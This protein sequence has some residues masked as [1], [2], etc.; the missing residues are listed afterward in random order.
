M[1]TELARQVKFTLNKH[2]NADKLSIATIDGMDWQ[3]VTQTE[4]WGDVREGIYIAIDALL[5]VS[6]PSFDFLKDKA[7][8]KLSNGRPAHKL[9]TIRLRGAL[10]HGLLIP[11]PESLPG[12]LPGE[13]GVEIA[14]LGGHWGTWTEALGIERY[15]PPI[16]SN[17]SGDMIR[18]PG[19]FQ[20]YT[21][22]ENAKN[23]P[24][25]FAEGDPVRVTEKIHGTNFRVAL[26]VDGMVT[27][28]VAT[29]TYMVGTHN[30][31]RDPKGTNAYSL[32][33]AKF[34]PEDKVRALV[35]NDNGSWPMTEHYII[36]AELFGSG[37]Q[38]LT[39]GCEANVQQVRIID[40]L[41]D[42]RYQGREVIE[43]VAEVLGLQTVPVLYRGP[44][45]KESVQALRDGA[46]TLPGA[47]HVREG[48][49]VT[50]EPE[51]RVDFYQGQ[52]LA[53]GFQGRKILKYISDAYLERKDA[54]DGH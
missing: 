46:S 50:S 33:A 44:F 11:V 42:G 43:K 21:H 31:A 37:I 22:I 39:Y 45:N 4:Q 52:Q 41:V 35:Q 27:D 51:T 15:E 5:D 12:M 29:P 47:K 53:S 54:K 13:T 20:S 16:P 48:V 26:V 1:A 17:M 23:F 6:L 32:A 24:D 3:C 19:A 9:K 2:P 10:S 40:V 38:D 34:L 8:K 30:T 18:C 7:T 14:P 28:G 36:F 25:V 49:V